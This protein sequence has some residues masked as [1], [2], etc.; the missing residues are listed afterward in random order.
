MLNVSGNITLKTSSLSSDLSVKIINYYSSKG[1]NK[2]EIL[3][4]VRDYLETDKKCEKIS[5]DLYKNIVNNSVESA[6][7]NFLC[8]NK[9]QVENASRFGGIILNDLLYLM[10][11]ESKLFFP[12]RD[13]VLKKYIKGK[14]KIIEV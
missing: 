6:L 3:K 1:F 11:E 12:L 2:N 10:L 7:F 8:K 13:Y 4:Y 14:P 5:P 9:I